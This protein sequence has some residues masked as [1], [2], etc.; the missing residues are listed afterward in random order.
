MSAFPKDCL[1]GRPKLLFFKKDTCSIIITRQ[2]NQIISQLLSIR[3]TLSF[4][5]LLRREGY[6]TVLKS[7]FLV[8]GFSTKSAK[9]MAEAGF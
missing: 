2:I 4:P 1:N 5:G 7:T 8:R 6:T 9:I 3:P